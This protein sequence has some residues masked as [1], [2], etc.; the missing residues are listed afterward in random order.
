MKQ[1]YTWE[2]IIK[3]LDR[4]TYMVE[5]EVLDDSCRDT[6]MDDVVDVVKRDVVI[7]LLYDIAR[8]KLSIYTPKEYNDGNI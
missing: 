7:S 1:V 5:Q 3:M 2:E 8:G 4:N 6:A